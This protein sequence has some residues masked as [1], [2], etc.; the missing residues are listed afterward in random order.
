MVIFSFHSLHLALTDIN[1]LLLQTVLEV[2]NADVN[3]IQGL[4]ITVT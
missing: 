2:E 1:D 3:I 4:E